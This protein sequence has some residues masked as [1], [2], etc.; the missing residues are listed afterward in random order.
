MRSLQWWLKTKGF[1]QRGNPSASSGLCA[2]TYVSFLVL[3][4]RSR[5][6][7][8]TGWGRLDGCSDQGLRTGCH[9]A[10]LPEAMPICIFPD[11]SAP[12]VLKWVQQDGINLLFIA[13]LWPA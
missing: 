9:G 13:L 1:S 7:S 8:F 11:H 12:G 5:D 3:G 2:N 10:D 4:P 6:A